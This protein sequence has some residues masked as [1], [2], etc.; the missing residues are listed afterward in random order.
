MSAAALKQRLREDLKAAMRE[1]RAEDVALLRKLIAALDNAEAVP[2]EGYRPR[3]V[4]GAGGE[5]ARRQLDAAEVEQLLASE[6]A[7]RRAA[8]E[9]FARLGRADE[10]ARLGQE[11]DLIARYFAHRRSPVPAFAIPRP[12]HKVAGKR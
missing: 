5:V 10:A 8:A 12:R 7:E 9:E 4:D 1:R 2:T 3:A 6:V 11:A